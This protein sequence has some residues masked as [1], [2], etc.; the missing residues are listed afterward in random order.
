MK[1][2]ERHYSAGS[3]DMIAMGTGVESCKMAASNIYSQPGPRRVVVWLLRRC[4][5]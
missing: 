2:V 3:V 5:C 4:D 1:T